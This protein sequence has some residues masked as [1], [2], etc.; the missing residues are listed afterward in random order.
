MFLLSNPEA[1]RMRR[2]DAFCAASAI[3]DGGV[4]E[5]K[6]RKPRQVATFANLEADQQSE[7]QEKTEEE[8]AEERRS[9]KEDRRKEGK[10]KA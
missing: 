7:E 6:L 8:I 3:I 10:R 1:R 2:T 9:K 5:L 4:L